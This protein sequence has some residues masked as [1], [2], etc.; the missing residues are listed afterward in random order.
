MNH[1]RLTN[2]QR[3]GLFRP[4]LEKVLA[5]LEEA[6]GSDPELLWALRRKLA[7]E[8]T[9]LERGTP[10]QRKVLKALMFGKQQGKCAL[11]GEELPKKG[12]ELDRYNA[13]DGYIESNVRLVHH[14]C[15]VKDQESKGYA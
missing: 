13:F 2:E 3:E 4:L 9:Y 14:Q 11:C 7:K 12:S 5:A 1:P 6:S 15:H 10:Q 8:L